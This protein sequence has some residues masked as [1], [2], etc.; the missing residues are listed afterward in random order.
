M[1]SFRTSW[2]DPASTSL[3]LRPPNFPSSSSTRFEV[4]DPTKS[5]QIVNATSDFHR[6]SHPPTTPVYHEPTLILFPIEMAGGKGKS[7]GGKGSGAKDSAGKQQKSHSAKAGL[8]VSTN[9]VRIGR[10]D[11][12][13]CCCGRRTLGASRPTS[14]NNN[15]HASASQ[16]AV[17]LHTST[18]LMTSRF[19]CSNQAP[20][21][22]VE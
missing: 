5:A 21:N 3:R 18:I 19:S 4:L 17:K 13:G 12:C 10:R 20:D 22:C 7:V 16:K 1:R 9:V 15:S 8:Q 11:F 6:I 2:L 14:V